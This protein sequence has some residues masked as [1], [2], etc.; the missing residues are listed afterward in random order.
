MASN[1]GKNGKN[2]RGA[3]QV[4]TQHYSMETLH[5]D[6]EYGV[7]WYAWLWKVLRPVLVFFCSL[8]VVVGIVTLVYDKIYEEF[9]MPVA[10]E[11]TQYVDFTI[12]SGSSITRI[13]EKLVEEHLLRNASVFKYLVTY[14]GLT[15]SISY[16][17]FS[18]SP[19]M[20]VN[21]II[22][23]LSSGSQTSE[24]TITI[25][26]GWTCEN[27]ADYLLK[28]GVIKDRDVF[29]QLCNDIDSFASSSYVLSEART[30]GVLAGR[31]Y[32]LEG[33]LAPDTYRIFRSASGADVIRKLLSQNNNVVDAVFYSDTSQ[34]V[35]DDEG[36]YT[37]VERYESNL[38]IDETIILA[39]IVEKEAGK[40]SD[41]AKVSA[42][43]HNR[44]NNGWRLEAD[45][46]ATY[47][48]G[49]DSLVVAQNLLQAVNG[50]NTYQ[51]NG[52]PVGPICNPSKAAI[53]AAL[54]P[55]LE[56]INGGYMYY[57]TAEATSGEL[58]F[59]RTQA[60]HQANVA[61]YYNSWVEYD[62]K[63]ASG[64]R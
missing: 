9:L 38:S 42:V 56:Y 23:E 8:L 1:R 41:Y 13:S 4:E 29:L 57:C 28:E 44:L 17:T 25:I 63:K 50:Y 49:N 47:L 62:Q 33:Y 24:R 60:E 40:T 35:A 46:T 27:I 10:P 52:L 48:T 7:F 37:E 58:V 12:E 16:G 39:S 22:A 51:K 15:N 26:P 31:R 3:Q 30:E 14:R 19:S 11:S 21:E 18:L 34:F 59:A 64:N 32:A 5:Q 6:R 54:Y 61:R 55:D 36:N 45:P 20:G 2:G 53:E 43:L